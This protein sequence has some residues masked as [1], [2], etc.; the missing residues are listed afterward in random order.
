[1]T[2]GACGSSTST[3]TTASARW[4]AS[5]RRAPRRSKP[6][7]V[8]L[9]VRLIR[10]QPDAVRRALATKGGANLVPELIELDTE[11]RRLV[12]ESE[13]LKALR[14]KAGGAAG[15][16]RG[17]GEAAGPGR[18]RRG[19][20]GERIKPPAAGRK[21]GA[22]RLET[23]A[24]QLPNLPHPSVPEGKGEDDNVEVRRWSEPRTFD[25]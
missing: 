8:V 2:R 21:W 1:R 23:L 7:S 9:D 24:L 3:P 10:E 6:S 11:R 16:A 13:D 19:E 12:R 17:G 25:F 14:N 18:P 22:G 20:A 15:R 5:T 4:R